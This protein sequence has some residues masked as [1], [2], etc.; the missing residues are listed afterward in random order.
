MG[1]CAGI[2]CLRHQNNETI[3]WFTDSHM[4]LP[5]SFYH[6]SSWSSCSNCCDQILKL[7]L[8]TDS[9]AF[10]KFVLYQV[11]QILFLTILWIVLQG[12]TYSNFGSNCWFQGMN[13]FPLL[14]IIVV[15]VRLK[16]GI[17]KVSSFLR[18]PVM[19]WLGEISMSLYLVHEMIIYYIRWICHHG[20]HQ[21]WP[22]SFECTDD[23]NN[24]CSSAVKNYN[25]ARLIEPYYILI[26]LP[27]GIAIAAS[28]YYFIEE[29]IRKRFK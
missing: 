11:T 26:I 14:T 29:P 3:P 5:W 13:V 7:N 23:D 12:I 1:I 24:S 19:L 4:F 25:S 2:L 22:N 27:I 17:T 28:L 9:L 20:H 18:H 16:G 6:C 10:R 15:L 21:I 8:N